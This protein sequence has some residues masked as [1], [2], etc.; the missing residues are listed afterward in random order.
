M[1]QSYVGQTLGFYRKRMTG[2]SRPVLCNTAMGFQESFHMEDIY[3]SLDNGASLLKWKESDYAENPVTVILQEYKE[4]ERIILYACMDGTE[5]YLEMSNPVK[6]R[7]CITPYTKAVQPELAAWYMVETTPTVMYFYDKNNDA[8]FTV[9]NNGISIMDNA[10]G[11]MKPY[12]GDLHKG[13]NGCM[14]QVISGDSN[15]IVIQLEQSQYQQMQMASCDVQY[16]NRMNIAE[17]I[18]KSTDKRAMAMAEVVW[19]LIKPWAQAD[20]PNVLSN[21]TVADRK[22]LIS[23]LIATKLGTCQQ[24][25]RNQS[26]DEQREVTL[27]ATLIWGAPVGRMMEIMYSNYGTILGHTLS[28]VGFDPETEQL[29]MYFDNNTKTEEQLLSDDLEF[30]ERKPQ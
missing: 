23:G 14:V 24:T 30:I 2:V 18:F 7:D 3:I 11:E 28:N 29:H 22:L 9:W 20:D 6:V 4:R 25:N 12:N 10:S 15:N 21:Q 26:Y 19:S 1:D 8:T 17:A 13:I 27:L 16:W 5:Q